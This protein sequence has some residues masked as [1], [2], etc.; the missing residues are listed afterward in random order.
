MI[1][2]KNILKYLKLTLRLTK[3]LHFLKQFVHTHQMR[4]LAGGSFSPLKFYAFSHL[5]VSQYPHN[6]TKDYTTK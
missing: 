3:V 4:L 6:N 2:C 5:S 1:M